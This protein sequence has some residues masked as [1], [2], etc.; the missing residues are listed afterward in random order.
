MTKEK[1]CRFRQMG[2]NE[3]GYPLYCWSP[4]GKKETQPWLTYTEALAFARLYGEK[5]VFLKE[6]K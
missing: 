6:T 2:R 1:L 4:D 3:R 5:A